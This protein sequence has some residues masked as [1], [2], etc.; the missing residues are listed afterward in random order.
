VLDVGAGVNPVPLM[1]A[2][3]GAKMFTVDAHREE[4]NLSQRSNWNEW[5][6][7]DYSQLD[8]RITSVR[9]SYEDWAPATLF[10]CIYSLS[11]IEH[12]KA[13]TRRVW[14]ERF[15]AQLG[16][17]GLLLLTIDIVP[18]TNRLWCFAEG[19]L[20]E[21]EELHGTMETLLQELRASGFMIET[22]FLKRNIPHS[23]VDIGLVRARRD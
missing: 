16:N 1:L 10:H 23:R 17:G 7:L 20:V 6:F 11:V 14:I 3:R 22:A 4:R 5:G 9:C 2:K 19:K 15:A 13:D 8:H 21:P 18:E 12:L